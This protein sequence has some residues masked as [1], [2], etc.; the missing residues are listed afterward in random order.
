[1]KLTTGHKVTILSVFGAAI[2][3]V[4]LNIGVRE[5]Y[6]PDIRFEEGSYYISGSTAVASL[7]VKNYGHS[8]TEDIALETKFNK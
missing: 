7:R 3:S 2:I 5:Y 6:S 8:D 1:M 4:I